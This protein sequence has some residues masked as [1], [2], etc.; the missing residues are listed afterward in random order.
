MRWFLLRL[1][2]DRLYHFRPLLQI[3]FQEL[4][5]L[6]GTAAFRLRALFGDLVVPEGA[7]AAKVDAEYAQ[8]KKAVTRTF[9]WVD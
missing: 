1:D 4:R 5:E 3:A 6:L 2:A 7:P 9:A 8:W